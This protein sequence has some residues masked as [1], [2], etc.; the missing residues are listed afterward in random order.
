ML[1]F[2]GELGNNTLNLLVSM[3]YDTIPINKR[4]FLVSKEF[5]NMPTQ[6]RTSLTYDTW[7]RAYLTKEHKFGATFS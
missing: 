2:G 5:E 7:P 6:S 3:K 4:N 1:F